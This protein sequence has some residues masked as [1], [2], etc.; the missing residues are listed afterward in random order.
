ML[1]AQ[2]RHNMR[3]AHIHF[4]I[5]KAGF[6]TQFAQVYSSDDPNLESDVQ[7]AVTR[8][9]IGHYVLHDGEPA[10]DAEVRGAWY[11]LDHHFVIDAGE[12]RLPRPPIT[13]KAVSGERP[14]PTVLE[15]RR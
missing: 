10:P 15:R 6:K 14:I 4:L 2:G 9:L 1:L 8:A 5:R 7:F 13:G 11:S 3:P 12:S